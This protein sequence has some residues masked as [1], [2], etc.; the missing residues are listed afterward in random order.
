V[1]R[2]CPHLSKKAASNIIKGTS[3]Q[4][5]LLALAF[6]LQG[7]KYLPMSLNQLKMILLLA[8]NFNIEAGFLFKEAAVV[9][10]YGYLSKRITR[11]ITSIPFLPAFIVNA[12]IAYGGTKILGGIAYLYFRETEKQKM[13]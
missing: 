7:S 12:I 8:K 9:F 6:F 13:L 3:E 4:N 10:T 11:R 2:E 1:G 5:G